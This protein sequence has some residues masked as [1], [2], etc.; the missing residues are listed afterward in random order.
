M[1]NIMEDTVKSAFISSVSGNC[2][3][4]NKLSKLK[5]NQELLF[6]QVRGLG[7]DTFDEKRKLVIRK[8]QLSH[9]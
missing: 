1:K 8:K 4:Q 2:T 3:S 9:R 5:H 6:N 7:N